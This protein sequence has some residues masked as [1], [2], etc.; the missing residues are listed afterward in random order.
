MINLILKRVVVEDKFFKSF[1]K[2]MVISLMLIFS[3][4]LVGVVFGIGVLILIFWICVRNIEDLDVFC[5]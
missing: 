5:V 3:C 2:K 1:Y 4:M